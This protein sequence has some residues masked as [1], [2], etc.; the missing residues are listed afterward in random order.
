MSPINDVWLPT[1][2]VWNLHINR[3][4]DRDAGPF[5]GGG[6][7]LCW[8]TTESPWD[9]EDSMVHV[10]DRKDAAPH[11]VI[12]GQKGVLHPVVTQMVPLNR[13]GRALQNDPTDGKATNM[14]NVIQVEICGYAKDAR[15]WPELRLKALANLTE[16]IMHRVPIVN[17]AAHSFDHPKRLTDAGWVRAHGHVGHLHAPDNDHTDPGA[18]QVGRLVRLID[19]VPQGGWAL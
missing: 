13:A 9:A 10:L 3:Y 11:F 17:V 1:G 14:A 12:G 16:L 2:H 4:Q 15:N 18:L 7:K 5:T 6:W 8:H 19:T